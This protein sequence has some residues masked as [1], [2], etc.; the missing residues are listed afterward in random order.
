MTAIA[1][2]DWPTRAVRPGYS[3]LDC[4]KIARAYGIGQPDWRPG[5]DA[6]IEELSEVK[7]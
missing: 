4:A 1:T 5:L 7:A 3:M 6:V 2:A